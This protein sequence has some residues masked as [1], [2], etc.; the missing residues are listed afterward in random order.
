MRVR[1][2]DLFSGTGSIEKTLSKL[3]P[4]VEVTS[5]DI[6]PKFRPTI[7]ADVLELDYEALWSPGY[8]DVVW[9]SPPC[10]YYSL[11]RNS[12]PRDFRKSDSLVK[13]G[14]LIVSYL[15]PAHFFMENPRAF[16]RLRPFMRQW[17]AKYRKT[18]NYCRYSSRGD[19]YKYPKPTDIWT[20]KEFEALACTPEKRCKYFSGTSHVETAQ[21]G[22]SLSVVPAVGSV[23]SEAVYRV[24]RKLIAVLFEDYLPRSSRRGARQDKVSLGADALDHR[25]EENASRGHD[26]D[27]VKELL[28]GRGGLRF[29]RN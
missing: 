17:N 20:N 11:A 26:Q 4:G 7:V 14:M 16:L 8:F 12:V 21:K 28:T 1:V 24:P 15:R 3:I 10:T 29:V 27:G 2:L 18:V 5:V 25:V 22:P 6:D 9:M 19:V 23:K 13:R